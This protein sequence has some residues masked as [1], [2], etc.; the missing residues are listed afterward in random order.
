MFGDP[1]ERPNDPNAVLLPFVWT[2]V[3]QIAPITDEIVEKA[4]ATCNGGKRMEKQLPSLRL[5][6]LV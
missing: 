1:C 2:Y 4:Q 5:M 3:H 6:W